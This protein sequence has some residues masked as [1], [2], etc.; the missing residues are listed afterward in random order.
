[1]NQTNKNDSDASATGSDLHAP[2]RTWILGRHTL[3][4]GARHRD[5]QNTISAPVRI[6]PLV[7][8]TMHGVAFG[9][10]FDTLCRLRL[11][12]ASRKWSSGLGLAA[13]T[14]H[15]GVSYFV[16]LSL[17]VVALQIASSILI[18]QM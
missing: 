11:R 13:D 10:A 8:T 5:F 18:S 15:A 9:L 17:K 7:M 3:L 2:P 12:S 14:G 16:S 6:P 4:I 1:M